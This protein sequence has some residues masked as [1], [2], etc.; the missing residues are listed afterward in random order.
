MN[1][2]NIKVT[3]CEDVDP[4]DYPD[5]VD[6]YVSEAHWTTTGELL[7]EEELEEL[8][9]EHQEVAQEWTRENFI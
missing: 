2:Q 8:N 6:A 1:I 4:R 7:T 5:F 3:H 9:E